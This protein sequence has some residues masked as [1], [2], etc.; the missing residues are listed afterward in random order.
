MRTTTIELRI[1][2]PDGNTLLTHKFG[3]RQ[4]LLNPGNDDEQG[5]VLHVRTFKV[6]QPTTTPKTIAFQ[7]AAGKF[8]F[9]GVF[10][11]ILLDEVPGAIAQFFI[12]LGL[13]T[14]TETE[15][16]IVISKADGSWGHVVGQNRVSYKEM[17]AVTVGQAILAANIRVVNL[18]FPSEGSYLVV[19]EADG[20]LLHSFP[21]SVR[22]VGAND[23]SRDH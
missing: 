19:V 22:K 20:L 17:A 11:N 21:F 18:E 10:Q 8:G 13:L 9:L 7:D 4:R 2:T 5:S 16:R 6:T 14:D 12:A 23:E 3:E 1:N 15:V